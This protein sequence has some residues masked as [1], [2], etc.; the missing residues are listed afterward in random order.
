MGVCMGVPVC[1]RGVC[2]LGVVLLG[3]Y[4]C[5]FFSSSMGVTV[6]IVVGSSEETQISDVPGE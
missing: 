5:V 1:G 3:V 2:L 4:M 6:L